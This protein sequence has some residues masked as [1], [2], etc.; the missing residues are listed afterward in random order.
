MFSASHIIFC[1]KF[2]CLIQ[3]LNLELV[4][5]IN[6]QLHAQIAVHS[7]LRGLGVCEWHATPILLPCEKNMTCSE[8]S[9]WNLDTR[10]F[11]GTKRRFGSWFVDH[12][13]S[14]TSWFCCK[15]EFSVGT[16]RRTPLKKEDASSYLLSHVAIGRLIWKSTVPE[17]LYELELQ[18]VHTH[19]HKHIHTSTRRKLQIYQIA[20][21]H[22][23]TRQTY[24]TVF[25]FI[26]NLSPIAW[27]VYRVEKVF[28]RVIPSTLQYPTTIYIVT[29]MFFFSIPLRRCIPYRVFHRRRNARLATA[30]RLDRAALPATWTFRSVEISKQL[31]TGEHVAHAV[32]VSKPCFNCR[33]KACAV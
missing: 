16:V 33:P 1:S 11:D 29:Y 13:T 15:H 27:I 7:T 2:F 3:L 30:V 25:F 22:M 9:M 12:A 21:T 20:K 19:A 32:W 6:K 4:W 23:C 24:F 8:P 18:I 5:K 14:A 28:Y 31:S 17:S 26:E 10:H